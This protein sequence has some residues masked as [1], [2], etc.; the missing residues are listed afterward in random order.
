MDHLR[1]DL[2]IVALDLPGAGESERRQDINPRLAFTGKY[3][4]RVLVQLGLHRPMVLGHSYGGAIALSL[5]AQQRHAVSS[6]VLLAPAHPY[7]DESDP[8]I[9][10]YLSRP[11]ELF[12]YLMPW[13]PEWLQMIGLRRMAGPQRV[14][15]PESLRPYRNNLRTPGTILHLLRLLRTWDKDMSGLRRAL[16]RSLQIPTLMLWGECDRAVPI[17][18]AP[19]LCERFSDA[20]LVTLPGVGHRPAE[21]APEK[22]AGYIHSWLERQACPT[23]VTYCKKVSVSQARTAPVI[24]S[25]F[26]AGDDGPASALAKKWSAPAIHTTLLGS[27]ACTS[28]DSST[29]CGQ[30]ASWS[31][32]TNSLGTSP[33]AGKNR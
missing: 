4:G 17:H 5:A 32:L 20:R 15:T 13:L 22:V 2:H 30:K 23:S 24:P 7:F 10:F 9:R 3:V 29:P 16:R 11:G 33:Q 6:L 12:A 18:S 14:D 25:S 28:V 31:P 27:G 1:P 19:K 26:E 8:V 21:E